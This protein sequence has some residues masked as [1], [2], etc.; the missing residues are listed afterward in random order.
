VRPVWALY[1]STLIAIWQRLVSLNISWDFDVLGKVIRKRGM[2]IM[3]VPSAGDRRVVDIC[4]TLITSKPRFANP[5]GISSAGVVN[6]RCRITVCIG[7]WD[8]G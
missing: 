1:A 5:T 8:L 3:S 2:F 6:G 4:L 7:F